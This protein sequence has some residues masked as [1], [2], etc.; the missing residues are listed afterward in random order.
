VV[1][2]TIGVRPGNG[3]YIGAQFSPYK[4][5]S[6]KG[7]ILSWWPRRES[8]GGDEVEAAT[9]GAGV[10]G[11]VGVSSRRR[12]D[13]AEAAAEGAR[14]GGGVGVSSGRP[15]SMDRVGDGT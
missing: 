2:Q 9:E 6:H 12:G 13:E 4:H 11:G 15:P 5:G 8:R 14:V 10:S 7:Y 1:K 3:P